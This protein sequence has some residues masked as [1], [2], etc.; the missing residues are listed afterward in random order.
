MIMHK[1]LKMHWISWDYEKRHDK[2]S[3]DAGS[4]HMLIRVIT[5]Q[6]RSK[7]RAFEKGEIEERKRRKMQRGSR[8]GKGV[9][10]DARFPTPDSSST[11]HITQKTPARH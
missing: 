11:C 6:D 2:K 9:L 5:D 3:A 8:S 10:A 1:V 7:N 4:Y